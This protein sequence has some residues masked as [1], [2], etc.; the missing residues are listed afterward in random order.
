MNE[1]AKEC[2]QEKVGL[3]KIVWELTE[4]NTIVMGDEIT[5]A[6]L[7]EVMETHRVDRGGG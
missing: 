4:L 1:A 2:Q 7:T 5:A 6:E 3:T